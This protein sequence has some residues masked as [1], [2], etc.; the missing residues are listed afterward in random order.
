MTKNNRHSTRY[1]LMCLNWTVSNSATTEVSPSSK[2]FPCVRLTR[3]ES[4]NLKK[5]FSREISTKFRCLAKTTSSAPKHQ[6]VCDSTDC[7]ACCRC[8]RPEKRLS[9]DA[10]N[11]FRQAWRATC[12]MGMYICIAPRI[13]YVIP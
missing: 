10:R 4:C 13:Q 3:Q 9:K 1:R 7:N 11:R 5:I 2:H 8:K 6:S 12:I